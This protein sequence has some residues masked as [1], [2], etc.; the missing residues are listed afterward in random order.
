MQISVIVTTYNRS[1]LVQEAIQSVLKQTRP[2]D[3]IWVIDD[4]STDNTEE[5]VGQF[6]EVKYFRQP[7]RGISAARNRGIAFASFEW[8]CFLDSDDL[9]KPKKLERQEQSLASNSEYRICYTDE[10][11][12]KDGLWKNQ[13]KIHQKFSGWIYDKCLPLCII[14]PSSVMIHKSVFDKVGRFDEALPACEDYDLWLRVASRFPVLFIDE[15]LIVKRAGDWPQLSKQHSLD[16]Y[17]ITALKKMLE[18]GQL[19]PDQRKKTLDMMQQKCFIY[20]Q[21]CEKHNRHQEL[22]WLADMEQFIKE[23]TEV[24]KT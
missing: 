8:L 21:G 13:K 3:E 2:A 6:P 15:R 7:N 12:R 16:K 14:S 4:G 11:W 22:E 17:R 5:V 10:E 24:I 19:S 9:W 18:S 20:R 23:H 1:G